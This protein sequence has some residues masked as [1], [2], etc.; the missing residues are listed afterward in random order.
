MSEIGANL[1]D[2]PSSERATPHRGVFT[3][4]GSKAVSQLLSK[5]LKKF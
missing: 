1:C 2:F 3:R 5:M 4:L